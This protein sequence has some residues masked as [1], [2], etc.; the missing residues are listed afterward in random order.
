MAG[1]SCLTADHRCWVGPVGVTG[2]D[3]A[4]RLVAD[5]DL[6]LAVGTRLQDFTTGSWTV[7]GD[8]ELASSRSTRPGSTRRSTARLPL[9]GDARECLAELTAA[10]GRMAAS[11]GV[12]AGRG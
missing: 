4:N 11:T 7:F 8:E 2:C 5:A 9:V 3:H 12:G 10:L 6:V 1:K